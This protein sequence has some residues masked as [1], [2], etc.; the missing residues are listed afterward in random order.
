M[1][2]RESP[3]EGVIKND[4]I[5]LS[6][7][8]LSQKE[9]TAVMNALDI[10]YLGMGT[11]VD[12][13]EK[14]LTKYL[15]RQTVCVSNDTSALHLALQ[16]IDIG[17]GDEVLIQSLTYVACFQ[18]IKATGATPIACDISPNTLTIDIDDAR[19]RLT[20]RTK[21][22][23]PV[24]YS[25]GV[26][27]L[28]DIYKFAKQN[29]LRV[30]EDAAHAFGTEYK[31]KKVG[32]FG[33][34]ACFSFDG[35]KNI[36]AGEGGCISTGDKEVLNK[37]KDARLLGI[38]NDTEKRFASKRSW[39]FSVT[40]QGWRYHMNDIMAAIGIEQ[41]KRIDYLINKRKKLCFSYQKYL[42]SNNLVQML[43][44][45]Y[46]QI[47]SHIFVVK[48]PSFVNRDNI[49][50]SLLDKAIQTGIHYF[51]NHRLDYFSMNG[52]QSLDATDAIYPRLITLPLHPNLTL[53][54]VKYICDCLIE[55]L[56]KYDQTSG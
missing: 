1:V 31:G 33:D 3:M 22:I 50:K 11:M 39:N 35:I 20:S 9:K 43:S 53:K 10:G 32:S 26:G 54:D 42:S 18:A 46:N 25:G 6:K 40:N 15:S 5:R 49:K 30:I 36:T 7:S 2:K 52:I 4:L 29:N 48:L 34:I 41:L 28:D 8:C 19:Q 37:I 24:H 51:P 38:E 13:F 56:T 16:A 12:L 45:D 14:N 44:L 17:P 27:N 55:E 47:A 21:A 23:M